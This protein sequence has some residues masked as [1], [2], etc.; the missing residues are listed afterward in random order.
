MENEKI[1]GILPLF[2]LALGSIVLYLCISYIG[3]IAAYSISESY[4]H[5]LGTTNSFDTTGHWIGFT[6]TLIVG[7][8]L[9]LSY[10]GFIHS[11]KY[12]RFTGIVGC[13]VLMLG[14]SYYICY[15]ASV[16]EESFVAVAPLLI[17]AKLGQVFL[18]IASIIL[19]I[20]TLIYWKKLGCTTGK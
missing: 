5:G 9:I 12:P 14:F 17:A 4:T 8:L 15:Y 1:R 20:A 16:Y 2:Y 3:S 7:I 18:L 10:Y 19:F 11:S 6:I 13:G